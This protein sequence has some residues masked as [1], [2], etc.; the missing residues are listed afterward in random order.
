MTSIEL[1]VDVES[2]AIT[3][4]LNSLPLVKCVPGLSWAKVDPSIVVSLII[5]GLL[6]IY[7]G[8]RAILPSGYANNKGADQLGIRAV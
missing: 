7:K 2:L 5:V 6:Q 1:D 8:T 3:C 4:V